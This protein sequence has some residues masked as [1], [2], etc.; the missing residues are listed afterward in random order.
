MTLKEVESFNEEPCGKP[1]GIINHITTLQPKVTLWQATGNS[2]VKTLKNCD[3]ADIS[4]KCRV[5]VNTDYVNK[6]GIP[7]LDE[8]V[9]RQVHRDYNEVETDEIIEWTADGYPFYSALVRIE[10]MIV[11]HNQREVSH[12]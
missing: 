9:R 4:I 11:A 5:R 6:V 12:R 8:F 10:R 2:Q 1:Q 7:A 3:G